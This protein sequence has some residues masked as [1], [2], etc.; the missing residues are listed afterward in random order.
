MLFIGFVFIHRQSI[1]HICDELVYTW[2]N[3]CNLSFTEGFDYFD[4]CAEHLS[5]IF[6]FILT[7]CLL[8][9][10]SKSSGNDIVRLYFSIYFLFKLI[11]SPFLIFLSLLEETATHTQVHIVVC[12]I[13]LLG[14]GS[15]V[16]IERRVIM[17]WA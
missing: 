12:N 1:E 9:V 8:K 15:L 4:G 5:F 2:T 16:E 6:I 17:V 11:S 13:C 14:L 10:L 3:W 7:F